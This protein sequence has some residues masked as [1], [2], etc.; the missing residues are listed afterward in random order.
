[1]GPAAVVVKR[2]FS[3][4][5]PID[6][7]TN[8]QLKILWSLCQLML[9]PFHNI[10][11]Q[12]LTF[13]HQQLQM[14]E[15]L[16]DHVVQCIF[17]HRFFHPF[18]Q[19]ILKMMKIKVTLHIMLSIQTKFAYLSSGFTT[20]ERTS[21][22]LLEAWCELRNPFSTATVQRKSAVHLARERDDERD[23]LERCHRK[24]WKVTN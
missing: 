15:E 14:L 8:S 20:K 11:R 7:K 22:I 18:E 1:M 2:I 17:K 19:V 21:G 12:Q 3:N 23:E 5:N 6:R 13:F 9:S 24:R 4:L 10:C 16:E